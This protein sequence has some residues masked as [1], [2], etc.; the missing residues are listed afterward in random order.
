MGDSERDRK[1]GRRRLALR[2]GVVHTL[3]LFVLGSFLYF[4]LIES[5]RTAVPTLA[6]GDRADT[7]QKCLGGEGEDVLILAINPTCAWCRA[8]HLFY[9]TIIEHKESAG[10]PI[11]AIASVDISSL[12]A[13]KQIH[14][15][16]AGG[17]ADS[18]MACPLRAA[19][20]S[21]VPTV[22]HFDRHGSIRNVWTGFLG[23]AQQ[24]ELLGSIDKLNAQPSD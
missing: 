15:E 3:L 9:R 1:F 5:D 21:G 24:K 11:S 20:V 22:I 2:E 13:V 4:H 17:F 16:A 23:D 12:V 10:A 7:F 6:Q 19:G 18:V 14:L 8:S